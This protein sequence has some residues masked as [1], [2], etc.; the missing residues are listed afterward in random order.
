MRAWR[1]KSA[2]EVVIGRAP[3]R[4]SGGDSALGHAES[5]GINRYERYNELVQL[6][7]GRLLLRTTQ[8]SGDWCRVNEDGTAADHSVVGCFYSN[9]NGQTW[10]T[11]AT[12]ADLPL[13]GAMEPHTVE[14]SVEYRLASAGY[15]GPRGH[16]CEASRSGGH[17]VRCSSFKQEIRARFAAVDGGLI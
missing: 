4:L 1:L 12:W 5:L 11:C 9:D 17:C 6:S 3:T 16:R 8:M 13:R 7:F 14:L 15:A 2:A 10:K